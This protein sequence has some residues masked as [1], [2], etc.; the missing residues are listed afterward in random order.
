MYLNRCRIPRWIC[1]IPI[2]FPMRHLELWKYS[3]AGAGVILKR[4]GIDLNRILA[5]QHGK[6]A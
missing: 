5:L 1:L 6:K 2:S 3:D 4:P